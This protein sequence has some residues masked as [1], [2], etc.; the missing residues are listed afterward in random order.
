LIVPDRFSEHRSVPDVFAG[1]FKRA[2][3]QPKRYTRIEAAL[4]VEGVQQ[5]SKS[6]I[7]NHQ[8]L[9]WQF[10]IVELDLMEVFAA[11]RVVGP[12]HLETRRVGFQQN[13]ADT[14]AARPTVDPCEDDEH[15]SLSGSADQRLCPI[16]NYAFT[17][18]DGVGSIVR[19]VRAGVRL[20]HADG[21]YA[22]ARDDPWKNTL[23]NI[24][25]SVCR[26]HTGLNPGLAEGGHRCNVTGL[27]NLLEDQRRIEYRQAKSA[28]FFGDRHAEH[29]YFGEPLHVFPRKRT[30]HI[31]LRVC[32]ELSLSEVAHRGHHPPLLFGELEVHYSSLK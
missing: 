10:A 32:L 24:V 15:A 19:Y 29:A 12:G 8:I 22:I 23:A 2:L 28:I 13:A 5:F 26:D 21:Q 6:V 25:G 11:H 4:R 3:G 14:L 20:S 30:I 18:D 27:R 17:P 7:A 1:F 9:E 31:P 16:Q